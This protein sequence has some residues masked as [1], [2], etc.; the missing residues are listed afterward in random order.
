MSDSRR[1]PPPL[2]SPPPPSAI[3]AA[4]APDILAAGAAS[5]VANRSHDD[6][7]R[8]RDTSRMKEGGCGPSLDGE[9]TAPRGDARD[10]AGSRHAAAVVVDDD[11]DE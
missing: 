2:L 11:I 5:D 7:D 10:E 3:P 9:Q 1:P 4:G 8:R 6:A